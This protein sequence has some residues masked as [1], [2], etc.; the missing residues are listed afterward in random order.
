MSPIRGA[1]TPAVAVC[2]MRIV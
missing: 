2:L 1:N